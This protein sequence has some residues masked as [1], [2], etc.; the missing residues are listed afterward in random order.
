MSRTL[1]RAWECKPRPTDTFK[2]LEKLGL[3][4]QFGLPNRLYTISSVVVKA[5]RRELSSDS[6]L[7]NIRMQRLLHAC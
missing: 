7:V 2:T 5:V 4:L 1:E 6:T 3:N